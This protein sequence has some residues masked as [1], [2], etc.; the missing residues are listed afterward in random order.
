MYIL[1]FVL[2]FPFFSYIYGI[3]CG[4][5][6]RLRRFSRKRTLNARALESRPARELALDV[7]KGT[8]SCAICLDNYSDEDL[9][10]ELPCKHIFH[11]EE[12]DEWLRRNPSCPV[13]REQVDVELGSAATIGSRSNAVS[14]ANPR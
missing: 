8:D 1:L 11:A 3:V 13:C 2:L 5:C 6:A 14:E 10:R 7:E 4:G 12:I 9:C